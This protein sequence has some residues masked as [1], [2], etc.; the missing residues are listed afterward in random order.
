[1]NKDKLQEYKGLIS[2][3][4]S[5]MW[6]EVEDDFK[7]VKEVAE[8]RLQMEYLESKQDRLFKE[9]GKNVFLYG[10]TTGVHVDDLLKEIRFIEDE[11]Q[12]KY[13]A[14]QKLKADRG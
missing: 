11:L 6:D 2:K 5:Q 9:F 3:K 12:K 1:M 13:L 4:L 8:L 7:W 14:V 10:E